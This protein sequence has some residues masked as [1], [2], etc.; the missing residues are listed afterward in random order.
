VP[1][2]NEIVIYIINVRVIIIHKL[3]LY[4]TLNAQELE[5]NFV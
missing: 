5:R 4:V 2:G 1:F 3:V